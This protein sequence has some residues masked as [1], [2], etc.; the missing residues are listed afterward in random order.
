MVGEGS[1]PRNIGWVCVDLN[2]NLIHD[3]KGWFHGLA[4]VCKSKCLCSLLINVIA[5]K[6][7]LRCSSAITCYS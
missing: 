6:T 1:T 2:K 7:L 3:F 5:L 4:H